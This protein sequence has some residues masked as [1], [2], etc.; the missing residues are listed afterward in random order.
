MAHGRRTAKSRKCERT[1]RRVPSA[2]GN[3]C[4]GWE[5]PSQQSV[6]ASRGPYTK[7]S[8]RNVRRGTLRP[9][10][11]PTCPSMD[12]SVQLRRRG[13]LETK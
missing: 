6:T 11:P 8:H 7:V 5:H 12:P 9:N 13:S 10:L 1:G 2:R 3:L 4:V